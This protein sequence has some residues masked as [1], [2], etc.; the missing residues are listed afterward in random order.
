MALGGSVLGVA[1]SQRRQQC[2]AL[3]LP[4][5][6]YLLGT[7]AVGDAVS[8]YLQPVE[9]IGFVFAGVALDLVLR[10]VE[11]LAPRECPSGS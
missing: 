2:I 1:I 11:V 9:W 10:F 6:L 3:L 5:L 7:F 8:R 4:L